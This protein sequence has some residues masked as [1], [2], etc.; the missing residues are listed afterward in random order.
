[1]WFCTK[2]RLL[3]NNQGMRLCGY[4]TGLCLLCIDDSFNGSE[5]I[6]AWL[7][8]WVNVILVLTL[9]DIPTTFLITFQHSE[10]KYFHCTWMTDINYNYVNVSLSL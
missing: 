3:D 7:G 8:C 2:I 1:M 6:A 9:Y 4:G 5:S 10:V